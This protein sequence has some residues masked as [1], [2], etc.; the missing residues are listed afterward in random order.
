[1]KAAPPQVYNSGAPPTRIVVRRLVSSAVAILE[2][3]MTVYLKL[4]VSSLSLIFAS[5][6]FGT[7]A[8]PG[9]VFQTPRATPARHPPAESP[10]RQKV[11]SNPDAGGTGEYRLVFPTSCEGT[12]KT[13]KSETDEARASKFRNFVERLNEV[14]AQG[15]RLTSFIYARSGLPVGVVKRSEV[16]YEYVWFEVENKY[17]WLEEAGG[18]AEKVAELSRQGFRLADY[19]F[20]DVSCGPTVPENT[21]LGIEAT[22]ETCL[23]EH[24][25]LFEREKGDERPAPYAIVKEWSRDPAVTLQTEIKRRL[26]EGLSPQRAFAWN[27]IWLGQ[28]Q[29]TDK[30]WADDPEVEIIWYRPTWRGRA[31]TERKVN[32][33]AKQGYRV[34][35][36]NWG[37]AVMYR[38]RD[39]TSFSYVWV[40][41]KGKS[42]EKQLARLQSRGAV[43]LSTY[44]KED[45]L[46]FEQRAADDGRR[47]E[48]K[49]LKFEF[50]FEEGGTGQRKVRV[51]LAPSGK[52]ALNTLDRLVKEGFAVRDLFYSDEV[53]VILERPT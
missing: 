34:A 24:L 36:T 35:L 5:L 29:A 7:S 52:E 32:E 16:P 22:G 2:K 49:V 13:L 26:A 10:G 50:Q 46:V 44:E 48:Y 21:S 4:L 31:I 42:F 47:R 9:T 14:G 18:F 33:L 8:R 15:Y 23:S 12:I 38:R 1:L 3:G 28:A 19:H 43:Y 53:S 20:F 51:D 17:A 37:M 39:D 45:K 40:D 11:E 30:R 27:V 6:S 25:F 41:A